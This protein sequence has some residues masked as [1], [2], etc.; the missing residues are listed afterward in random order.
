MSAHIKFSYKFWI[1]IE[2]AISITC[3]ASTTKLWK[4]RCLKSEMLL[5]KQNVNNVSQEKLN[6]SVN[7]QK[8]KKKRL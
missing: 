5:C 3:Y 6:V 4:D 7:Y 2:Y 8:E 1:N